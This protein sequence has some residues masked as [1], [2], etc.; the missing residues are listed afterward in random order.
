[1]SPVG[2]AAG[3]RTFYRYLGSW[4]IN[5]GSHMRKGSTTTSTTTSTSSTTSTTTITSANTPAFR[6]PRPSRLLEHIRSRKGKIL[7]YRR[8]LKV[9]RRRHKNRV[10][11][12][13]PFRKLSA[14]SSRIISAG[15]FPISG[16][17]SSCVK[18][19]R[20]SCLLIEG[21]ASLRITILY[22]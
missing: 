10:C 6:M 14:R 1:M 8:S 18:P 20:R 3:K 15:T 4:G 11:Q 9:C 22:R 13:L 12:R 7:R 17:R 5:V 19:Y 16:N 2:A 21:R